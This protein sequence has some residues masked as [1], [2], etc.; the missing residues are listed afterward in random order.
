MRKFMHRWGP[1]GPAPMGA[2]WDWACQGEEEKAGG[3]LAGRPI[4]A[5]SG[6][7]RLGEVAEGDWPAGPIPDWGGWL[8][9]DGS[10]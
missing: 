1:A 10:G 8:I 6:P 3:W 2:A 4:G 9:G 7:G 5:Q